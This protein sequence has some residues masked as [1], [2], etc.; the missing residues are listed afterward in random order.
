MQKYQPAASTQTNAL[1]EIIDHMNF[2]RSRTKRESI[3]KQ[4]VRLHYTF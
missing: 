2:V 3:R 1:T 4:M